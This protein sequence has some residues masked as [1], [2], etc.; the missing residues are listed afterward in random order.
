MRHVT[1]A[2]ATAVLMLSAAA[3][4]D[5][6]MAK[7]VGLYNDA[8]WDAALRELTIAERLA[9]DDAQRASVWLHQGVMLANVPDAE[10]AK[11]AWRRALEVNAGAELPLPVSP[12]VKALFQEVQKAAQAAKADAPKQQ[13]LTPDGSRRVQVEAPSHFP[14]WPVVSLGAALA[15][16]GIGIGFALG[17]NGQLQ[18][19]RN[20]TDPG[21]KEEFRQ[22]A[23][24]QSMVA[25]VA[26]AV[27]GVAAL[28]ALIT[29]IVLD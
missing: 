5:A 7:A 9:A 1:A 19:S 8:E 16:G 21:V 14:I 26:F 10:A 17:A 25:N 12:R 13:A 20:T 3:P 2:L 23:A 6:A 4:F 27:A 28:A 24:T 22:A 18:A 15:A 29:F 11:A